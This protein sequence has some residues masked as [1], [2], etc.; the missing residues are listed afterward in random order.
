MY[1][2]LY[3]QQINLQKNMIINYYMH[4]TWKSSL[5]NEAHVIYNMW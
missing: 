1:E 3:C 5:I 2:H 4:V